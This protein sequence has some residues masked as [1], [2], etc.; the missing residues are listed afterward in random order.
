MSDEQPEL[1]QPPTQ[2][3]NLA[4]QLGSEVGKEAA[5]MILDLA[6]TAMLTNAGRPGQQTSEF[7]LAVT[8]LVGALLLIGLGAF[9]G[10]AEMQ[11][12]GIELSQWC[13][14]GYAASR[15]LSK[16]GVGLATGKK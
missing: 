9:K 10:D 8:G 5:P 3:V 11:T 13:I 7:K 15:G 14:V 1:P 4:I 6:R 12:R 16:I 2:A